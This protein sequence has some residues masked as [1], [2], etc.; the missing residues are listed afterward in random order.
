MYIHVALHLLSATRR[1]RWQMFV[2]SKLQVDVDLAVMWFTKPALALW[3]IQ[4]GTLSVTPMLKSVE[5]EGPP[6][7]G[8]YEDACVF[9]LE[10]LQSNGGLVKFTEGFDSDVE[11]DV[12]QLPTP[13]PF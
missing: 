13:C 5:D 8:P 7:F 3:T 10:E 1:L 4:H 2:T 12:L 11:H 6:V 9:T